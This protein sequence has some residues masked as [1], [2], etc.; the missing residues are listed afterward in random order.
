MIIDTQLL[1]LGAGATPGLEAPRFDSGVIERATK[2]DRREWFEIVDCG[3]PNC[4]ACS[5]SCDDAEVDTKRRTDFV[6]SAKV[7]QR[8]SADEGTLSKEQMALLPY[9]IY[10][11]VLLSLNWCKCRC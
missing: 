7:L 6:S 4:Y 2:A 1:Y 3:V 5:K 8:V 11:Y 10:G 9:R